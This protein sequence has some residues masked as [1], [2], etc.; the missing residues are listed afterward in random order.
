[1]RGHMLRPREHLAVILSLLL[2]CLVLINGKLS[3]GNNIKPSV[4]A[5]CFCS[6]NKIHEINSELWFLNNYKRLFKY[7]RIS[8]ETN[9]L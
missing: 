6:A 2:E 8:S 5:D 3:N 7:I 4:G 9:S 1:M